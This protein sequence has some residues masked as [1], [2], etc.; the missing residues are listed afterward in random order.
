M[1]RRDEEEWR[2]EIRTTV[3][4]GEEDEV[5]G[6]IKLGTRLDGEEG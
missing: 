4:F 6:V 5:V 1:E 3:E 2:G